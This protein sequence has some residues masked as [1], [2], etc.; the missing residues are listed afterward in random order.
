M[1]KI[2]N[3]KTDKEKIVVK[4]SKPQVGI[5]EFIEGKLLIDSEEYQRVPNNGNFYSGENIHLHYNIMPLLVKQ[6]SYISDKVK[7]QFEQDDEAYRYYLRGRVDYD[8]VN[9]EFIILSSREFFQN[10]DN[11]ER[12][13]R[14]FHIY[15]WK[16]GTDGEIDEFTYSIK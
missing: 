7:K 13:C 1:I 2:I 4:D 5:F 11:I 14:A 10:R 15:P 6:N 3:L 16:N 12:V 9:N 8:C